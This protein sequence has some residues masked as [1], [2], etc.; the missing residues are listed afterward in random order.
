N[1]APKTSC[2]V[3]D[4]SQGSASS[5]RDVLF[6]SG[7]YNGHPTILAAWLATL[8]ALVKETGHVFS[9]TERLQSGIR[10]AFALLG[11]AVQTVVLGAIFNVVITEQEHVKNYRE[12]QHA[13]FDFRKSLDTGLLS[14]GIYTKPMNRYSLSTAHGEEEIDR[15]LEAYRSVLSK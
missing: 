7:T 9:M 15:T 6:H 12:L 2:D 1:S 14:E 13:D 8:V 5:A 4:N 10:D 3:F 11:I